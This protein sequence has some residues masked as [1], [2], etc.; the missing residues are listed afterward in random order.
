MEDRNVCPRTFLCDIDNLGAF[1]VS[2]QHQ[3]G[4]F[5][6]L[7][8]LRSCGRTPTGQVAQQRVCVVDGQGT[9]PI[10]RRLRLK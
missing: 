7:G 2:R 6:R 10:F 5:E 3:G 4:P 9:K 1:F 8:P